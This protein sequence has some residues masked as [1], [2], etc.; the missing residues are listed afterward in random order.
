M[1]FSCIG[2]SKILP[3]IGLKPDNAV[4]FRGRQRSDYFSFQLSTL[5]PNPGLVLLSVLILDAIIL[6]QLAFEFSKLS[7]CIGQRDRPASGLRHGDTGSPLKFGSG[8]RGKTDRLLRLLHVVRG[9]RVG[10][11]QDSN[12]RRDSALMA[13]N[14][15]IQVFIR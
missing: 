8:L 1:A 5:I 7:T 6:W 12:S 2:L 3:H 4:L 10:Q 9:S 14:Q 15:S 13:N 11:Q